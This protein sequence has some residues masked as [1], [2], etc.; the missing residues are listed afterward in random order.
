ML[1]YDAFTVK[2]IGEFIVREYVLEKDI[3]L[4]IIN[5]G[6]GNLNSAIA[7]QI[8]IDHFQPD[9][10]AHYGL[11]FALDSESIGKI[12]I[13]NDVIHYNYNAT[14][15]GEYPGS[16]SPL[17]SIDGR[18]IE[19]RDAPF[20][21][22]NCTVCMSG[23]TLIRTTTQN[24][25]V[26]TI[27]RDAKIADMSSAGVAMACTRANI[28]CLIVKLAE[29]ANFFYGYD[30]YEGLYQVKANECFAYLIKIIHWLF[31]S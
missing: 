3:K 29:E 15:I 17:I 30:E 18:N 23:D 7:T 27:Y 13:V 20:S 8:L 22:V 26:K 11:A 12:F 5:S 14:V 4:I 24:S 10:I 1:K 9:C 2:S 16:M 19:W 31:S 28:P 21:Q 6:N 25:Y